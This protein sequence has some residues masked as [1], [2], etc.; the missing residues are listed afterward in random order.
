MRFG[1][2][3]LAHEDILSRRTCIFTWG[4]TRSVFAGVTVSLAEGLTRAGFSNVTI[5]CPTRAGK[6][7]PTVDGV[8]VV[9]LPT[10]R[11][12]T[13]VPSLV[14]YLRD[15]RPDFLISA[16][17]AAT[18]VAAAAAAIARVDNTRH[19]VFQAD[20][21]SSDVAIE[22]RTSLKMR[23]LIAVARPALRRASAIAACSRGVLEILRNEG[24]VRA[25][26]VDV[27]PV[28]VRAPS[29]PTCLNGDAVLHP[30]V[31]DRS[32]AAVI[33][34]VARLVRRKN[35]A[36]LLDALALTLPRDVR[37]VVFGKG[38]ERKRLEAR[39]RILGVDERV[40]FAGYTE[41]PWPSVA[42][43]DLFVMPST[44]EAFCI[45]IVEAMLV[46]TPVLATDAV[47]GGPREILGDGDYGTLVPTGNAEALAAALAALLED[48][49][50]RA[51][52]ALRGR[53]RALSFAPHEVGQ[54]WRGFLTEAFHESG[55][56]PLS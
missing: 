51:A 54:R 55:I 12:S 11:L 19:I 45:A 48:Q 1:L 8:D 17:T 4:L 49:P 21:F 56:G 16:P 5:V 47:G 18:T 7:L 2:A 40:D 32:A 15:Y 33:T 26:T 29:T 13:S 44:D 30:W 50:L 31:R 41:D 38:P 34:T 20:T 10:A 25:R 46:G 27:I 23:G 24:V 53:A 28:P 42:A 6:T 22:H 3:R 37:L 35:L 39:A 43:S 52:F 14:R 9:L 36:L